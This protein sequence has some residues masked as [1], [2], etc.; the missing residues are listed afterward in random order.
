MKTIFSLLVVSLLI[1]PA[2]ADIWDGYDELP[3]KN[4]DLTQ[5]SDE[6][7][8]LAARPGPSADVDWFRVPQDAY[9]SYEVTI[10]GLGS[11]V[12]TIELTRFDSSG[13][14]LLQTG[15]APHAVGGTSRVLE[16]KNGNAPA[17]GLI[18]V[19][20]AVCGATCGNDAAYRIRAVET[21]IAVPKYNNT[22]SQT[23]ALAIQNLRPTERSVTV[24]LRNHMGQI[25]A[26]STTSIPALGSTVVHTQL[27][28][29]SSGT[30]TI[31]HDAGYGGLAARATTTDFSTGYIFDTMGSYKAR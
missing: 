4:R 27:L 28:T 18:R 23:T 3:D 10:D 13:T 2:Q 11:Q 30:I 17:F 12:K 24:Y 8:A 26:T 29:G 9:S 19:Q 15:A 7:H 22:G 16:W 6:A 14:T 31:A 25:T 20:G 1:A 21:T 5:G